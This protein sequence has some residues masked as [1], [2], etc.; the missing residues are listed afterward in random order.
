MKDQNVLNRVK[1]TQ[2]VVQ[3]RTRRLGYSGGV[4]NLVMDSKKS[5]LDCNPILGGQLLLFLP[6][7]DGYLGGWDDMRGGY[8]RLYVDIMPGAYQFVVNKRF[9]TN[10][11]FGYRNLDML[12][13][14]KTEFVGDE[15]FDEAFD[16][17]NIVHKKGIKCPY[18]LNQPVQLSDPE[19][20]ESTP[21][22][23]HCPTCQLADLES[24][25]CSE[26]IYKVSDKFNSA[27]LMQLRDELIV[28][29]KAALRHVE[30][31]RQMIL[32]DIARKMT[33]TQPGRNTLNTIDRIHLKMM[34]KEENQQTNTATDMIKTL[35]QEM[36]VAMAGTKVE[37]PTLSAEELAE[38]EAY[39]KRKEQMAKAREAKTKVNDE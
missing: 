15:Y 1:S 14:L 6:G 12:T 32:S 20:G 35:A 30:S 4:P 26:R 8:K 29:N 10:E 25:A 38:Y 19:V 22:Y 37:T 18:H 39:K 3:D 21:V 23:Q 36:A 16:Y 27:I 13:N 33:G 17:F 2:S 31:K 11:D 28:A 9:H 34:H 5:G 7:K 24:E